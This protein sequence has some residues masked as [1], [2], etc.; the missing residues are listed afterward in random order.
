MIVHVHLFARARDLAGAAAIEVELQPEATV[1]DLRRRLAA[2][3][4][5]LASL[6]A[7]CACAVGHEFVDDS[8]LLRDA[9]EVA[10]LPPVSGG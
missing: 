3:H 7:R 5:A 4:P 8:Y 9:A 6:L 10:V 1:A 2:L